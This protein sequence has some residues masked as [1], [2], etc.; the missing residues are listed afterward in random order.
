MPI[1]VGNQVVTEPRTPPKVRPYTPIEAGNQVV[2]EPRTPPKARD[3]KPRTF[4]CGLCHVRYF[5]NN[6]TVQNLP[7][8]SLSGAT[9]VRVNSI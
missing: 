8:A 6:V 5:L 9:K 1:E 4:F 3:Y 2:T 7:W